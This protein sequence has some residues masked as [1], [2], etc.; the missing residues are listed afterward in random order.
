MN[1]TQ[2]AKVEAAKKSLQE[3]IDELDVTDE[4]DDDGQSQLESLNE[5][6]EVLEVI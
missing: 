1:Q 6:M 5:A 4:L 2:R 3:V